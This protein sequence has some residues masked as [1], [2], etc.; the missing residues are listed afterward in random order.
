MVP[1]RL[2]HALIVIG[3]ALSRG[4]PAVEAVL[5]L[6]NAGVQLG[7]TVLEAG[8]QFCEVAHPVSPFFLSL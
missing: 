2:W 6:V 8:C 7:E 4:N 1:P 5:D 3:N